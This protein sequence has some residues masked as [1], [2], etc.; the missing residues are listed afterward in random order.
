MHMGEFCQ[1]ALFQ[2]I[3]KLW[4][5]DLAVVHRIVEYYRGGTSR[6]S[7][8]RQ[9]PPYGDIYCLWTFLNK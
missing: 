4:M 1:I 9:V 7:L 3:W 2:V 6:S 5:A 8:E